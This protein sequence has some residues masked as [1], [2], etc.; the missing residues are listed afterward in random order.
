MKFAAVSDIH[1]NSPALEAVIADIAARGI[2]DIV[3]IV[4]PAVSACPPMRT[5]CPAIM[6]SRPA[7]PRPLSDRG[8]HRER[9][10]GRSGSGGL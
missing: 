5:L 2:V 10:D 8:S 7:R 6:S 4:I 3:D 1:G 9:M